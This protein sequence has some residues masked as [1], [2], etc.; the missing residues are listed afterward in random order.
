MKR[1]S[2]TIFLI[3]LVVGLS[4][5]LCILA[6]RQPSAAIQEM[7]RPTTIATAEPITGPVTSSEVTENTMES[8]LSTVASET[9]ATTHEHEYTFK[10]TKIPTCTS[11]GLRTYTC[12]C[13]ATYQE[14]IEQLAHAYAITVQ[15]PTCTSYGRTSYTCKNCGYSYSE[16]TQPPLGHSY[17]PWITIQAP[18][19]TALGIA[20]RTCSRC[21]DKDT[22][23]LPKN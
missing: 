16:I 7:I 15:E 2:I 12:L 17:G 13:G 11:S 18:S 3:S 23:T 9:E 14:T 19:D 10:V 5:C 8:T 22:T 1:D 4:V 6:L 20:E 21:G